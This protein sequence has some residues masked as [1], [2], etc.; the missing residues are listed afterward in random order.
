MIEFKLAWA[1]PLLISATFAFG[2]KNAVPQ[3]SSNNKTAITGV[4]RGGKDGLPAVTIVLSDEGHVLSGATLFYEWR[5][6]NVNEPFIA[7][8]GLPE[9]MLDPTFDGKTLRFM[10]S[11]RRAH[12]P[13]TLSDQPM[14]FHLILTGP[15]TAELVNDTEKESPPLLLIRSEY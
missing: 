8:P 6:N 10:I 14:R 13:R 7:T 15:G 5:R 11:H 4:W 3:A 12:P 2:Q 9:P 1:L